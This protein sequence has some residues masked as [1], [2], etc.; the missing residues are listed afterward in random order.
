MASCSADQ[1]L[2]LWD[3]NQDSQTNSIHANEP[4]TSF[5]F[6]GSHDPP[7]QLLCISLSFSIRIYK[8]RT[9][10]LIQT[11]TLNELKIK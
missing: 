5:V 1:T 2:K 10:Q 4:I 3:F 11:I 8:V 7:T 9:L 6:T